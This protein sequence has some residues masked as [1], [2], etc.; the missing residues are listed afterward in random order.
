MNRCFFLTFYI[1]K[2]V[3]ITPFVSGKGEG[4]GANYSLWMIYFF[5]VFVIFLKFAL[6]GPIL[7]NFLLLLTAMLAKTATA[8]AQIKPKWP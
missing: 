4:E 6:Q 2:I 7:R 3:F 5:V 8:F 1:F